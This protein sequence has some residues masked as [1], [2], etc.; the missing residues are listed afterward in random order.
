M[1]IGKHL[2]RVTVP[3]TSNSH[4]GPAK[5]VISTFLA[6]ILLALGVFVPAHTWAGPVTQTGGD[7]EHLKM[8]SGRD[9]EIDFMSEMIQHHQSAID[10]SK[11]APD[12]A[13]HQEVKDAAQKIIADQTRE[14]NEMTD[15]LQ[16]W[17]NI[18]PKRGMMHD[19]PGMG[20]SDMM[21]LQSL[22]GDDF[23]KQFLTMMQM[24]HT[25]AT[26]MARLVP[27]RATHEE[28]K[29][30][31][32]NVI[33]SQSAEIKEFDG[34]L[35]AWSNI[36]TA[37]NATGNATGGATPPDTMPAGGM[38]G[39]NTSSLPATGA[40]GGN[41]VLSFLAVLALAAVALTGG[42]W[43]RRRTF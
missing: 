4:D 24:H 7:M 16:Q 10:M 20:M 14:I 22:K 38:A 32:Q 18:A 31:G 34:W 33:S 30:L 37:G 8:L 43:V 27:D 40:G 28:L 21:K 5:S 26:D 42:L 17:Y 2:W 9:F 41:L 23:D 11:F 35:S 12:R 6:I 15:W 29:T 19:M 36:N 39:G 1:N 13:S 3:P 25:G